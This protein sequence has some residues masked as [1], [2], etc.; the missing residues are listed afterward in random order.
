MKAVDDKTYRNEGNPAVLRCVPESARTILDVGCGA[1]D[2]ARR[3]GRNGR[4]VDGVTLSV[5]E[6]E[7]AMKHCRNVV[8][9]DLE[10]GLPAELAG[11]YDCVICSHVLE[12]ICWPEKLLRDIRERL[13]PD[14]RLVVA[15]P[16]VMFYKNRWNL[17]AGRFDYQDSGLMDN[18]HFRWYTFRSAGVML[19]A[20]GF[21]IL[22][23]EAEGSFPI[24][25]VRKF[26]PGG[27]IRWIDAR[28]SAVFPG[29]FGYQLVYCAR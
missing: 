28:A 13:A 18:T 26:L 19:T 21:E 16:N 7:E 24:P 1:G 27:L 17:L 4:A 3:L 6:R 2:N 23:A 25:A 10:K 14:G 8:I 22:H 9:H 11:P 20:N 29:L 15:L 12:H 5:A